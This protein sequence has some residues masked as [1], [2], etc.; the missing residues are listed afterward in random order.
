M[1]E[2]SPGPRPRFPGARK[3]P[4]TGLPSARPAIPAGATRWLFA[5]Y[6]TLMLVE[7]AGLATIIT[8]LRVIRFSTVLSYSLFFGVLLTI[9]ASGLIKRTQT[10]L[11]LL[12]IAF[13]AVSV[14]WAVVQWY[15]VQSI[16]PLVDYMVLFVLTVALVDRQSRIDTIS[17]LF[18]GVASFLV[19]RNL[20]KLLSSERVGAF[21]APYFMGDGNDL[22][23]GLVIMLPFMLNLM[24]GKRSVFTRVAGLIGIGFC[25]FGV[26]GS[27]SRGAAIGLALALLYYWIVMSRRK[28][29]GA[30]ALTILV[31]AVLTFAPT[32]YF[33]R[34]QS[35]GAYREDSSAQGRLQVWKASMR[36]AIDFPLGVGAGNFSSAYGRYYI[37]APEQNTVVWASRRWLGA[38]SIYFKVLGE[39]GILGLAL[40]LTIIFRNL[41]DNA[42]LHR[43]TLAG[44]GQTQFS[45]AWPAL[46]NMSI[47]GYAAC[48][49]FLGGINY[50]HLFLLSALTVALQ[51]SASASGGKPAVSGGSRVKR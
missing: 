9:G 30:M 8:P 28:A 33:E 45:A 23:W 12:F 46:L 4:T 18:L 21:K 51:Q 24:L 25:L 16:R 13:T 20:D 2:H 47:I 36:M 27:G 39:Y 3:A 35:I 14:I 41:I 17:W 38:H 10:R 31:G 19:L 6:V 50:P 49:V 26:I 44:R 32:Y 22:A 48:G 15:A 7:Y 43:E 1:S 40:L 34:L 29:L 5:G 37:P 11:L 42:R